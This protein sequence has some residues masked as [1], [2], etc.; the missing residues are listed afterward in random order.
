MVKDCYQKRTKLQLIRARR[1]RETPFPQQVGHCSR[2]HALI[3]TPLG[4]DGPYHL[5][6]GADGVAC[7]WP[8]I[9]AFPSARQAHLDGGG[10]DVSWKKPN[11]VLRVFPPVD[12]QRLRLRPTNRA[13][14]WAGTLSKMAARVD[15]KT[16]ARAECM[17]LDLVNPLTS[18][19]TSNTKEK[20]L[21]LIT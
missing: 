16:W 17:S 15:M 7:A 6:R 2:R 10:H 18:V 20:T 13:R 21:L 11:E 9:L 12:P 5:H 1:V 8:L 4:C 14:T 3:T 19:F